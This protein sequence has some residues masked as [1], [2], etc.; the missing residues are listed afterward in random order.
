V[1]VGIVL[2]GCLI[3][4]FF[5]RRYREERRPS[6]TWTATD[7]VFND[8]STQRVVR[9]WLDEAGTRHYVPEGERPT[10]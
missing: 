4:S 3:A 1:I 2:L 9:V 5:V 10:A 7:E 8:P 6:S